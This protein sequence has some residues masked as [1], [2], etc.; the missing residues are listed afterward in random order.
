M[1]N[2][3]VVDDDE[4]MRGT[5]GRLLKLEGYAVDLAGDIAGGWQAC[6][7]QKPS[8]ILLDVQLPDGSGMDLCARIKA[9]PEFHHI[10]I[11]I[12]TGVAVT[13]ENLVKGMGIGAEDYVLKPFSPEE[14]MARIKRTLKFHY[15]RGDGDSPR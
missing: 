10:P 8:L 14:L 12:L 5:L 1:Y 13:S 3:L 11:F 4:A 7:R 9:A 2:I 6:L 15:E